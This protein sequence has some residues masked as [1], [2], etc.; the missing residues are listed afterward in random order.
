M[1]LLVV[2]ALRQRAGPNGG[3]QVSHPLLGVPRSLP[4]PFDIAGTAA[5]NREGL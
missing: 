4:L 5:W 3:G 1:L 2:R